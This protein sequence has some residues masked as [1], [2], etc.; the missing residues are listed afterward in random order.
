[1]PSQATADNRLG[2][3]RQQARVDNALT[4]AARAAPR[5]CGPVFVRSRGVEQCLSA[6]PGVNTQFEEWSTK[7]S[8]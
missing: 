8:P 3:K 4:P 6:S 2:G 1:M 7:R 5:A